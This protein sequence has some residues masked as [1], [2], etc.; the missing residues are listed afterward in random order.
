MP[1]KRKNHNLVPVANLGV[2][3]KYYVN[4]VGI[5]YDEFEIL[6]MD[7]VGNMSYRNNS[8]QPHRLLHCPH[9]SA[10]RERLVHKK[11]P[12]VQMPLFMEVATVQMDLFE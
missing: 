10:L 8:S 6:D 2:G 1:R 12:A 11:K 9:D 7:P 4:V 5:D 3:D